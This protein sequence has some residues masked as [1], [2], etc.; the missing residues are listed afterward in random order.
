[1]SKMFYSIRRWKD[2]DSLNGWM[3][4]SR[5]LL[6]YWLGFYTG[7]LKLLLNFFLF[8]FSVFKSWRQL[9]KSRVYNGLVLWEHNTEH[10]NTM[11]LLF[12]SLV[13][14]FKWDFVVKNA[15]KLYYKKL[16]IGSDISRNSTF[17]SFLFLK[18]GFYGSWSERYWAIGLLSN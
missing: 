4:L 1:M 7:V 12:R 11:Y 6:I 2:C 14:F 10:W 15:M 18:F 8:F 3:Y 16:W 17:F 5:L 13:V 9:M